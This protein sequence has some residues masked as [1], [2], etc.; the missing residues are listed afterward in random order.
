[1]LHKSMSFYVLP[2]RSIAVCVL[3]SVFP[4]LRKACIFSL[5]LV[6][7][8][9]NQFLWRKIKVYKEKNLKLQNSN[10]LSDICIYIDE[11]ALGENIIHVNYCFY[12]NTLDSLTSPSPFSMFKV[13]CS[14]WIVPISCIFNIRLNE[15]KISQIAHI[16]LNRLVDK[17]F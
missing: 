7:W 13:N 17:Q 4:G 2:P 14:L 9:F 1:M 10:I 11:N 8:Y 16:I 5:C 3:L 12:D 15:A 6:F